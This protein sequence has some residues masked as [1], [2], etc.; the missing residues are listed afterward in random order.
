MLEIYFDGACEPINPGGTASYGWLIKKDGVT[1]A[2]EA[3]IIGSG[4]G[5]TN[6]VAEYQGLIAALKYVNSQRLGGPVKIYSDSSLVSNMIA[7]KWGWNKKKTKWQPHKNMP[8]L[9]KL[10]YEV[11]K[12]LNH[13]EFEINWVTNKKNQE[14]DQL[15]KEPLIRAG[16]KI[17]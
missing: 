2:K 7:K 3:K 12:L 13:Y 4:D 1:I 15:S 11:F 6:N 9:K 8:H 17:D 10:L 16:I 5:M 14:A